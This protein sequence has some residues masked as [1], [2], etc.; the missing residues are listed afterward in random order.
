MLFVGNVRFAVW[1][2]E[3]AFFYKANKPEGIRLV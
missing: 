1:Q 2:R 3:V